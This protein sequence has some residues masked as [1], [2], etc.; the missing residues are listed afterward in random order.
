MIYNWI[1]VY[2]SSA[3]ADAN[4]TTR[5]HGAKMPNKVG[6]NSGRHHFFLS[7]Q[8]KVCL[9]HSSLVFSAIGK[10]ISMFMRVE[11]VVL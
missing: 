5:L 8:P 6:L 9:S 2:L 11:N 1:K 3:Q 4:F 10:F 7:F